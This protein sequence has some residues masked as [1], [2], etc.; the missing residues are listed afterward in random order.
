MKKTNRKRTTPRAAR[1][2]TTAQQRTGAFVPPAPSNKSA[3]GAARRAG[4]SWAQLK[5]V[6]SECASLLFRALEKHPKPRAVTLTVERT[7]TGAH[8]TCVYDFNDEPEGGT[9]KQVTGAAQPRSV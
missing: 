3:A 8:V 6:T 2:R 7:P 4:S 9:N 1:A 5:H